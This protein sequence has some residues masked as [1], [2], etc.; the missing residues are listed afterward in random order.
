MKK[1]YIIIPLVLILGGILAACATPPIDDMNSAHE[2]VMRAENDPNVVAYANNT[3]VLARDA[4]ARMQAE[5]NARRYDTARSLAAETIS[6]AERAIADGR[7]GSAR[8]RDEAEAMV[9]SLGQ[10]LDDTT[11]A[12]NGAR[13]VPGIRLDFNALTREMD[14]ARGAYGDVQ[15]S[16]AANNFRDVISRGQIIRSMLADINGRI[17]EAMRAAGRK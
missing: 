5:S 8:A 3:L 9:R 6:L 10:A 15:Q 11:R 16:F 14:V 2:A 12:I 1:I 17:S 13:T 4:L 7:A